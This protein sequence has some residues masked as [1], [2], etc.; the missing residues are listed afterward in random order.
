MVVATVAWNTPRQTEH[1][2]VS[3]CKA[4]GPALVDG[5][6][7]E[8]IQTMKERHALLETYGIHSTC[9]GIPP[10]IK[11]LV[12]IRL[13]IAIT[14]SRDHMRIHYLP[15]EKERVFKKNLA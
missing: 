8:G 6:S 5:D 7:H 14:V 3:W 11:F 10:P 9:S 15:S 2:H 12:K 13:I 1:A 4:R